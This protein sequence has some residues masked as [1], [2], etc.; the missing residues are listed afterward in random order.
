FTGDDAVHVVG[1]LR[2]QENILDEVRTGPAGGVA[3]L[4]AHGPRNVAIGDHLLDERVQLFPGGGNF[5]AKSVEVDGAVPDDGL[6]V[7]LHG[8]AQPFA[9][10]GADLTPEVGVVFFMNTQLGDWNQQVGVLLQLRDIEEGDVWRRAGLD[11]GVQQSL[12]AAGF[13]GQNDATGVDQRLQNAV[14]ILF[15]NAR[16]LIKH[17]DFVA[18]SR[19][20]AVDLAGCRLAV[21]RLFGRLFVGGLFRRLFHGL[22]GRLFHGLFRRL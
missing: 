16:P 11:A 5:I 1:A 20:H 15:F 2:H 13:W 22:L 9:V 4:K 8:D 14:Q 3:R 10:Y 19:A 17:G 6:D 21:V 7:G 18:F 12:V